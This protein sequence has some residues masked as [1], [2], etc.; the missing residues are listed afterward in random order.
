TATTGYSSDI[1]QFND[2]L[3]SGGLEVDG[4]AFFDSKASISSNLQ[5]SGRFIADTLASHSFIGDLTV[6]KEFVSSGTGSSSFAGSLDVTKGIRGTYLTASSGLLSNSLSAINSGTLTVNAFTLGGAITGNSQ[7]INNLSRLGIGTTPVT[8]LEVQGTASASYLL[9]GNT[10]QVGGYSSQSYSRFGTSTTGHS[11]YITGSND[12]LVSGDIEVIGTG[13]FAYASASAYFGLAFNFADDCLSSSFI[14]WTRSTGKFGCAAAGM[15]IGSP[16]T[17]GTAGSVLFVDGSG[18]LGQNNA[19]FYWDNT[20]VRLG[21][22]TTGPSTKFEVQGTAS[23]SYG[24]FGTLQVGGYASTAYS[25]FGTSTTGHSNYIS[26]SNDVLVSGDLETR[27]T[28]SFGGVASVSGNFFTYGANTFS[29]T[30]SSSF[31]GSLSVAKGFLAGANNALVV[32]A[33]ATADTLTI[34]GGNV[35]IGT[36]APDAKLSVSGDLSFHTNGVIRRNTSDGSDNGTIEISGGGGSGGSRGGTITLYGN[37]HAST[38]GRVI[39]RSGSAGNKTISFWRFDNTL[40]MLNLID[41]GVNGQ[42]KSDSI[43]NTTTATAANMV[44][45]SSILKRS[46]SSARYKTNIASMSADDWRWLLD[47]EP[48]TFND[49]NNPDGRTFGGLLAEDVAA[50]GPKNGDGIPLFAG[51]DSEG[52]P[53]DVAYPHLTAPI[54]LG[55][56]DHEHRIASLSFRIEDLEQQMASQSQDYG[57]GTNTYNISTIASGLLTWFKD[58]LHIVFEDGLLRVA[59]IITD[60]LTAKE[61]ATE[62]LCIGAT[63]VTEAELKALLGIEATPVPIPEP[64]PVVEIENAP[65]GASESFDFTTG[66]SPE[67]MPESGSEVS[68]SSGND[69][70]AVS[71]TSTTGEPTPSPEPIVDEPVTEEPASSS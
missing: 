47:V 15:T 46:T 24:L 35:G 71:E 32:N 70:E 68:D 4:N 63:C 59:N 41:D 57:L 18:N 23:A 69:S 48:I 53:D 54:I 45:E 39:I 51:L 61:V 16:V 37:E 55:L 21:I 13:S 3:I 49:K 66:Q 28:A 50:K 62:K 33:N 64:T 9:T 20:N 38:P 8:T 34:V 67:P 58:S 36:T 17:D 40:E 22:G 14:Q 10:L 7:Q 6:T 60:K 42:V 19:N 44:I 1:S 30:G 5:I 56:Q 11:N 52:R 31:A 12:L 25:R 43:S 29:G 26:A 2:L 65:V 27:G